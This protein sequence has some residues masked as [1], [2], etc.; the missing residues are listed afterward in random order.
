MAKGIAG[1]IMYIYKDSP[2]CRATRTY[3]YI[4]LGLAVMLLSVSVGFSLDLHYCQGR[5]KSFSLFGSAKGCDEIAA[6][7]MT[8]AHRE[9]ASPDGRLM[10]SRPPCCEST[11]VLLQSVQ[12]CVTPHLAKPSHVL[13]PMQMTPV[14]DLLHPLEPA[15]FL[16]PPKPAKYKPPPLHRNTPVYIQNFRF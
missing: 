6:A 9:T 13:Q 2:M 8:C 12:E 10:F 16:F 3:R 7:D 5:V 15:R 14:P 4:A 1:N 11:H